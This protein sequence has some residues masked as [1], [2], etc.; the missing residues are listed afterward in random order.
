MS[1]TKIRHASESDVSFLAWAMLESMR[2]GPGVGLFEAALDGTG[3][4]SLS[5]HEAMLLAHANNWGQIENFLI[6]ETED[7]EAVGAM[8]AFRGDISDLRPLTGDGY[9]AVSDSL[10]WSQ[11][12]ARLFWQKFVSFFGIFGNAAQL[13][14]PAEYVI[15]YAAVC[16]KHR[17]K[18]LYT[19]LLEAHVSR[20]RTLGHSTLGGTAVYGNDA[21]WKAYERFGFRE[22]SRFGPEYYRGAYPGMIRMVYDLS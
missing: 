13:F 12:V 8:A 19:E 18:G 9:K 21:V 10:G 4:D 5:F 1:N 16:S 17:R 11:A 20:A 14:Q 6:I 22:H 2:P 7:G 3:T 15:E